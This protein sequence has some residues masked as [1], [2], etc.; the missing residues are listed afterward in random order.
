MRSPIAS[1][2]AQA[3]RSFASGALTPHEAAS[4]LARLEFDVARLERE[5]ASSVRRADKAR[6]VLARH[7]SD[8]AALL[9]IIAREPAV[10]GRK[11]GHGA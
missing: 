4:R 10:S 3:H 2:P 8:R 5:I 11:T 1:N 7:K 6:R 9:A